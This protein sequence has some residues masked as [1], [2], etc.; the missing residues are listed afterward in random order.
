MS[1]YCIQAG[2]LQ[3]LLCL[4]AM[5][6]LLLLFLPIEAVAGRVNAFIYHRFGEPRYASTNINPA[7]FAAQLQHLADKQIPV[8]PL[9]TVVD[10]L[11][12]GRPLPEHAVVLTVDDGFTSFLDTAFPL[13]QEHKFPITL[14]VNTDSV[15]A[16]GYL[17]W[18]QL[19][20]L[21]DAGVTIGNH[22]STHDYLLERHADE[23]LADWRQRVSA[24]ITHA[25]EQFFHHMGIRPTLFAYPYGEY[26]PEL[27]A[28]VQ[29]LGFVAAVAQQSGVIGEGADLFTLPRFPMGGPFASMDSFR[30]K[31]EM[32]PLQIDLLPPLNPVLDKEMEIPQLTVRL[33]PTLYDLKRLQGFVQG[34]NQLLITPVPERDGDFIVE[35]Q[36]P[37]TGRRNKYTL[38][39][40]IRGGGWAWFSQPW[41]RPQS[42]E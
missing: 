35:A 39:V 24:D 12:Q 41:F 36:K 22:T 19:K 16:A 7:V 38:T 27:S 3:R 14:F 15:G 20:H 21:A 18:E 17:T 28:I 10:T 6:A 34:D 42:V 31:S 40:P 5:V 1:L 30:S 23:T 4:T 26:S 2:R 9:T 25:Q 8:L 29:Q 33:S 11:R 13:L 37:V 32:F